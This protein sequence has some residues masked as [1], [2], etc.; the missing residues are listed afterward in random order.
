[1]LYKM[2]TIVSSALEYIK[3][4]HAKFAKLIISFNVHLG[5]SGLI[6]IPM[7]KEINRLEEEVAKITSTN[8]AD[9]CSNLK[10][11]AD[12]I[13]SMCIDDFINSNY[14]GSDGVS[15]GIGQYV[16][17]SA[18]KNDLFEVSS[19][20]DFGVVA[21][22]KLSPS[23]IHPQKQDCKRVSIGVITHGSVDIN[24]SKAPPKRFKKMQ[25]GCECLEKCNCS[26]SGGSIQEACSPDNIVALK[27]A[28]FDDAVTTTAYSGNNYFT[29]IVAGIAK[30][31]DKY[32][33]FDH[34]IINFCRYYS[35]DNSVSTFMTLVCPEGQN[36]ILS[37]KF[38]KKWMGAPYYPASFD[39]FFDDFIIRHDRIDKEKIVQFKDEKN[40]TYKLEAKFTSSM[41]PNM[42][43]GIDK[44]YG[45]NITTKKMWA[46]DL[47]HKVCG[48][49]SGSSSISDKMEAVKDCSCI[50]KGD[51]YQSEIEVTMKEKWDSSIDTNNVPQEFIDNWMFFTEHKEG[52]PY[53]E[54]SSYLKS[55]LDLNQ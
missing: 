39:D 34:D 12:S 6:L 22:C 4:H 49:M 36:S 40:H 9:M 14:G 50:Y 11:I 38:L 41:I 47:R 44:I 18:V 35:K 26:F 1:M 43:N 16:N 30:C 46:D 29:P 27:R 31:L 24:G 10:K 21:K 37:D 52:I 51:D 54:M 13:S 8:D 3:Q 33:H 32:N 20:A 19:G 48:V 2:T 28:V 25:G 7:D 17:I 5:N 45:E 55:I 15:N 42:Y 53:P 23:L